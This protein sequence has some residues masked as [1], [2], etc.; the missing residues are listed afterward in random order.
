MVIIPAI[1]I[2]DGRCVRLR[3]GDLSAETVYSDNPVMMATQWE[4]QGA[5]RLHLVDLNGAVDGK[6]RHLKEIQEI[7]ST[8]KIPVEVGG[9]IRDISTIST[10]LDMGVQWVILGTTAVMKPSII[11]EACTHF[12]HRIII[13]LD[14]KD[15]YV[16]WQGW[17]EQSTVTPLTVLNK[18]DDCALAAVVFTDISRDG[19]KTGPNIDAIRDITIATNIPLIVSGGVSGIDDL[20]ALQ[21]NVPSVTG[22]IVGKALYDGNIDLSKAIATLNPASPSQVD[23]STQL[24]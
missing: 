9:G 11:R 12:P 21:F 7:V 10:Y 1:D 14:V 4:T 18:L 19:M 13:S 24:P 8:L 16:A 5:Q 20:L 2:K 22:V 3:Q 6:P 15:G 23:S 17:V